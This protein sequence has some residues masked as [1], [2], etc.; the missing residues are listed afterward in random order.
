[1][2]MPLLG[3]IGF[4]RASFEQETIVSD[5]IRAAADVNRRSH[6]SKRIG[7]GRFSALMMGPDKFWDLLVSQN[8]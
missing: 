6:Q 2:N 5:L 8:F 1:M 7:K 3:P 4:I